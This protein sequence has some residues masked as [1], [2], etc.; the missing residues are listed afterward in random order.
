MPTNSLSVNSENSLPK[1][2]KK[3][4]SCLELIF[5]KDVAYA[6]SRVIAQYYGKEHKHVLRD[7]E[8]M[9]DKLG[10]DNPDLDCENFDSPN[11]D[12]ENSSG[13]NLSREI[14]KSSYVSDRG[15]T[16]PCYHLD[17]DLTMTL[18]TGYDT[19]LRYQLVKDWHRMVNSRNTT[20]TK[21]KSVRKEFTDC[22]QEHGCKNFDF[23]NITNNMKKPLEI[24]VKHKKCDF[25][26]KELK[27]I[28]AA[29]HVA[30]ILIDDEE[31]YYECNETCVEAS[32]TIVNLANKKKKITA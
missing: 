20:R 4:K 7:I 22:L 6:D 8:N 17:F 1:T 31:G 32:E 26:E 15:K 21:V 30:T 9:F 25:T 16:Y 5:S 12:C 13:S 10:F 29:E 28:E 14:Y 27:L 2:M 18:I 19:K 24:S 23:K 11:L 3:G